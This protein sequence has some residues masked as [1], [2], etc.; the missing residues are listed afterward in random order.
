MKTT[1]EIPDSLFREAKTH[2]A[3]QGVPLRELVERGLRL[4]LE[5]SPRQG[6]RFRLKT[7]STKGEGLI[8]DPDWSTIRSI[9]YEGH[10]E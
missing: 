5:A 1:I 4:A 7:I 3:R 6:K 9:V 8:C 10:G 2:A